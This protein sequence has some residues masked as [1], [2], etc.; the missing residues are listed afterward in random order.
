MSN[1]QNR[2]DAARVAAR[3]R[4]AGKYRID[5]RLYIK[6]DARFCPFCGGDGIGGDSFDVYGPYVSQDMGCGNCHGEWETTYKMIS[7][8]SKRE[9]DALDPDWSEPALPG[10]PLAEGK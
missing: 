9:P 8:D 5:E 3:T 7:V 10:Y 6:K 4:R 1:E 2:P